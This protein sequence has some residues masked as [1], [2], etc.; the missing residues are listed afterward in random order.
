MV[1]WCRQVS[2]NE[3]PPVTRINA[4]ISRVFGG[5]EGLCAGDRFQSIPL[6]LW[7]SSDEKTEPLSKDYSA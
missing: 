1:I 4:D 7:N 6:K 2:M 5:T 3:R